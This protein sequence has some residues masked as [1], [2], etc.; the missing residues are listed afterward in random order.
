MFL[1]LFIYFLPSS[2]YKNCGKLF[3][4]SCKIQTEPQKVL[5]FCFSILYLNSFPPSTQVKVIKKHIAGKQ[6]IISPL[7][8]LSLLGFHALALPALIIS[9]C[10]SAQHQTKLFTRAAWTRVSCFPGEKVREDR[11]DWD[12]WEKCFGLSYL[13]HHN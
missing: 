8:C 6:R 11:S 10:I 9:W 1:M 7:K 13:F 2:Q 5:L 12:K 4:V 3:L